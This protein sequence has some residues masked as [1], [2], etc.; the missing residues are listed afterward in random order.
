M[1]KIIAIALIVVVL[2]GCASMKNTAHPEGSF[3]LPGGEVVTP[4]D[5]KEGI[6]SAIG[7]FIGTFIPYSH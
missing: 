4:D 6:A 7:I 3:R 5:V 1:K 2:A